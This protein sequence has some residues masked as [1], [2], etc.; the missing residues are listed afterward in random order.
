MTTLINHHHHDRTPTTP[1]NEGVFNRIT[2]SPYFQNL[3]L[4]TSTLTPQQQQLR[5]RLI[6]SVAITFVILSLHIFIVI[7]FFSSYNKFGSNNNENIP[8]PEDPGDNT[9]PEG[10]E[11]KG[12]RT[13]FTYMITLPNLL[14]LF[15]MSCCVCSVCTR[16][17]I[18]KYLQ[19]SNSSTAN[20]LRARLRASGVYVGEPGE[21]NPNIFL[22]E[23]N[24]NN[25]PDMY[26]L[27]LAM[28]DRDFDENDYEALLML[29]DNNNEN[30]RQRVVTDQD[31]KRI[32]ISYRIPSY[33]DNNISDHTIVDMP[34]MDDEDDGGKRGLL[35]NY[36]SSSTDY[37]DENVECCTIQEA[38]RLMERQCVI[39]LEDYHS[40]DIVSHPRTCAHE[41]HRNCISQALKVKPICP[42]CKVDVI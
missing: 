2:N 33:M 13:L 34:P 32:L 16:R 28:V 22:Q 25:G 42:I 10:E 6:L 19:S 30:A 36:S 21:V 40:D 4:P 35:S 17:L 8:V 26:R 11:D 9:N 15:C 7:I 20:Y 31:L 39:C 5:R 3:F 24:T 29:D 37:E 38:Q 14:F 18:M 27:Q 41:F 12:R 1:N 23:L